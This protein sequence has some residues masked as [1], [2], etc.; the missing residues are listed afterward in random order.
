MGIASSSIFG[1]TNHKLINRSFSTNYL[2]LLKSITSLLKQ[3][4]SLSLSWFGQ[5]NAIKMSILLKFL[6]LFRVLPIPIPSYFLRLT[7][8][9]IMSFIWGTNKPHIPKSTLFLTKLK[10]GLGLPNF[11]SYYYA[12]QLSQL[13]KYHSNMETPLWVAVESVDIDPISVANMLW[14]Q[15]KDRVHISNPITKHCLA[16]WDKCKSSHNLQSSHNPLLPF[17]PSFLPSLEIPDVI[18]SLVFY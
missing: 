5:I 13:P 18:H 6:Y 10:G 2:P 16:I 15:P 17:K 14:L 8:R 9:R 3:W 11:S 1:N 12:A 4:S 7:Q